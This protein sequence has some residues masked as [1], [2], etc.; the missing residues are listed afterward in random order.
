MFSG[1]MRCGLIGIAVVVLFVSVH[2]KPS[3]A[4]H[5][6]TMALHWNAPNAAFIPHYAA[7]RLGFFEQEG[8]DVD[9]IALQ[10]SV[11]AVT[12]VSSGQVQMGQAD[13]QAIL[14]A[15]IQ[16]A[17]IKAVWLFY[18]KTPTGVISF[19]KKGIRSLQDLRGKTISTSATSPD[20]ILLRAKLKKLGIDP[21]RDTKI[22]VV[23][24][25]AKLTMMLQGVSDA[26][27]GFVNFQFIQAQMHG[28][29]KVSF[30]PFATSDEPLYGHAVF[31]NTRFLAEKPDLVRSYLR[32]MIKGL[33]WG[34]DNI[35]KAIDLVS[36]WDPNMKIDREFVLRDWRTQLAW[37][38]PSVETE[39]RGV[40]YMSDDGW[41]NLIV[42]LA[43]GGV[44]SKD[45]DAATIYT[46]DFVPDS[47]KEWKPKEQ[48]IN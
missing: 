27:T 10:G 24:P 32:A 46:N 25:V 11:A 13:S 22:M 37:L 29:E 39:A 4:Q 36:G 17:P 45:M 5:K 7:K 42:A 20:G 1:K 6:I 40:G 33:Y 14:A 38:I 15:K 18:Q 16:G 41:R 34:R 26:G 19:D 47:A 44:G 12:P 28:P 2:P 3:Q 48:P 35:E 43:E 8:L 23:S 9:F 30:I 31:V 21:D